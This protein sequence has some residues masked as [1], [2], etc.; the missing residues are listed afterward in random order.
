MEFLVWRDLTLAI[1]ISIPAYG[2]DLLEGSG[3]SLC[4]A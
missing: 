1:A 4:G 2:T 3:V